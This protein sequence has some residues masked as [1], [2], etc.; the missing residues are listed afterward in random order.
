MPV[1]MKELVAVVHAAKVK[2]LFIWHHY[3]CF[4]RIHRR[5][6][7]NITYVRWVVKWN[8]LRRKGLSPVSYAHG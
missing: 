7:R 5:Q 4:S 8:G 3:K 1:E 2:E 6:A